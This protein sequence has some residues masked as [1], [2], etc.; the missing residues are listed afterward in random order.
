MT[1]QAAF[2]PPFFPWCRV[3]HFEHMPGEERR[4]GV[5]VHG[6]C[7]KCLTRHLWVAAVLLAGCATEQHYAG[8]RLPADQ[9]AVVRADPVV[10][11]GLPVQ[12]RLRRVDGRE[13]GISASKVELAAGRHE[14]LVDCRVEESGSVRRFTLE[15]DLEAGARYRVVA[16]ATARNCEAV[17]LLED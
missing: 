16:N 11:A 13:V 9:R 12:L 10:S 4:S 3:K 17:E 7:S 5:G 2:G 8:P 15:A 6:I 14:I 1:S